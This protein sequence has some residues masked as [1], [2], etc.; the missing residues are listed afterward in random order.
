[1]PSASFSHSEGIALVKKFSVPILLGLLIFGGLSGNM[2]K[3]MMDSSWGTSS[4]EYQ[5]KLPAPR[6]VSD[7]R[8]AVSFCADGTTNR[9]IGCLL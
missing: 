2:V 7:K 3:H 8:Q 5:I 6:A 1:M 9:W 4:E